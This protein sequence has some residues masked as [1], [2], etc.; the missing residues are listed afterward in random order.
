VMVARGY[1]GTVR[2]AFDRYLRAG[3]PAHVGHRKV[4][5]GEACTLI[6]R[7]G[8]GARPGPGPRR[9]RVL[10]RRAHAGADGALPRAL[11]GARP[12]P[13]RR[14][15]FSRARGPDRHP[16]SAPGAVGGLGG[17]SAAGRALT[18]RVRSHLSA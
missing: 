13:H 14:V 18:P 1:V 9:G 3:G 4:G 16:R 6:R 2:E 5:P 10:L 11:S 17:P 12:R 7:A 8:A 15:G